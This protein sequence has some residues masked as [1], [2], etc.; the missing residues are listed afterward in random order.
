M[1]GGSEDNSNDKGYEA[2]NNQDQGDG[3]KAMVSE[4]SKAVP[5][6][7]DHRNF[8][9]GKNQKVVRGWKIAGKWRSD[10]VF[11]PASR[12]CGM[13]RNNSPL[14]DFFGPLPFLF[15]ISLYPPRDAV[16]K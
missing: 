7:H 3:G 15:L 9:G 2:N 8:T 6:A 4:N 5:N 16:T 1:I 11:W 13:R 14:G 12:K 10:P